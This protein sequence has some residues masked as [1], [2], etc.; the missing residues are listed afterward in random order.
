MIRFVDHYC[1]RL[2]DLLG[3]PVARPELRWQG[4][5]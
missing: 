2:M 5:R 1:M 3:L 4:M